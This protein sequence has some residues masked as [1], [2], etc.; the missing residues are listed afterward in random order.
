MACVFADNNLMTGLTHKNRIDDGQWKSKVIAIIKANFYNF[1]FHCFIFALWLVTN[2]FKFP[3][4]NAIYLK[5]VDET[6]EIIYT[7]N[8]FITSLLILFFRTKLTQGSCEW[9]KRGM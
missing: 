3:E 5:I 4:C 1:Y 2:S 6:F 9:Q 7:T 8:V